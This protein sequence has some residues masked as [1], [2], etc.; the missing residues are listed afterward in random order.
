MWAWLMS[1]DAATR[2]AIIAGAATMLSVLGALVGVFGNLWWNR[3]Q[4][5]DE[6]SLNLRRD[7]YL[8]AIDVINRADRFALLRVYPLSKNEVEDTMTPEL[9]GVC[10]KLHILGTKHLVSAVIA[11][12]AGFDEW[13]TK[14]NRIT[15]SCPRLISFNRRFFSTSMKPEARLTNLKRGPMN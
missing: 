5:R 8:E 6:R 15:G 13:L 3:R 12:Q 11:F 2:A 10:A 9:S 4:H 14:V 1:L 7:V